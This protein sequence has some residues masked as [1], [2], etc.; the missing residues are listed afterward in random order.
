LDD[1]NHPHWFDGLGNLDA[2]SG[3]TA[4]EPSLVSVVV[5]DFIFLLM[6][7]LLGK[8]QSTMI[9]GGMFYSFV[10]GFDFKT[11]ASWKIYFEK[12]RERRL[13]WFRNKGDREPARRSPPPFNSISI[14]LKE[15]G[16]WPIRHVFACDVSP[17]G[18]CFCRYGNRYEETEYEYHEYECDRLKWAHRRFYWFYFVQ[19]VLLGTP[20]TAVYAV[21]ADN[22]IRSGAVV[23]Y[24]VQTIFLTVFYFWNRHDHVEILSHF[25]EKNARLQ[26]RDG[27]SN[28][29]EEEEE[30]E[31]V[32]GDDYDTRYTRFNAIYLCW[33]FTITFFSTLIVFKTSLN[34]SL[35]IVYAWV[36]SLIV[37]VVIYTSYKTVDLFYPSLETT[38]ISQS[39]LTIIKKTP[40]SR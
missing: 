29:K 24:I 27:F 37:W 6:G 13:A 5:G 10:H 32:F 33:F 16:L 4:T 12:M 26:I 19:V 7:I 3:S 31:I 39:W 23:Y 20:A 21:D 15:H 17:Y 38:L 18:C 1:G 36:F 35:M 22:E 30:E 25:E 14:Y 28:E 11:V 34:V 8:I 40:S 2:T 9:D